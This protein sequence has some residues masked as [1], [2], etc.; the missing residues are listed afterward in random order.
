MYENYG[1]FMTTAK[2]IAFLESEMY[3]LS[4]MITE[5]RNILQRMAETSVLGDSRGAPLSHDVA[6]EDKAGKD[7]DEGKGDEAT[8][9]KKT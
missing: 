4:H 3:Q 1:Q 8:E 9:E 5:Q 7:E 2:E 6:A